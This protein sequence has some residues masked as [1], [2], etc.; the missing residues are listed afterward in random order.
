MSHE[1]ESEFVE[2]YHNEEKQCKDC[3]SFIVNEEGVNY[4]TEAQS[5]VPLTG[6]CNFFQSI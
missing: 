6:H 1:I 3:T 4:C 5:E 2:E